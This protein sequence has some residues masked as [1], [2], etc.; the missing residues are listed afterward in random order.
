MAK[1][2]K[3][4]NK[5]RKKSYKGNG[6]LQHTSEPRRSSRTR[7]QAVTYASEYIDKP[8]ATSRQTKRVTDRISDR[9]KQT[10]K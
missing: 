9:R 3:Y 10:V 7:T 2:K 1:T 5:K 6:P 4:I 8:Q